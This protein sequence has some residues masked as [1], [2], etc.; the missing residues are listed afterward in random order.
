MV[1]SCMGGLI[2]FPARKN[3]RP[4]APCWNQRV[5]NDAIQMRLLESCFVPS[6]YASTMAALIASVTR[7]RCAGPVWYALMLEV[8]VVVVQLLLADPNRR[9]LSRRVRNR[10]CRWCAI[11][12]MQVLPSQQECARSMYQQRAPVLGVQS[13]CVRELQKMPVRLPL[14]CTP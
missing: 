8:F 1:N 3:P 4:R 13:S 12:C 2:P 10:Q 7:T 11:H 14:V 6:T 9:Q 5:E